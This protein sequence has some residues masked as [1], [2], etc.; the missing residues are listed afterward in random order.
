MGADDHPV[1]E[2]SS[3]GRAGARAALDL[4]QAQPAATDRRQ[5]WV[6]TE[7][8]HFGR[9]ALQCVQERLPS[10]ELARLIIQDDGKH[11]AISCG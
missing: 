7:R 5:P 6:V 2:W 3:A 11:D 8:R 1:G 4:D 9:G 10:S